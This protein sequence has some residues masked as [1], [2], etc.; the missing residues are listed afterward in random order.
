MYHRG[1]VLL[2]LKKEYI[3]GGGGQPKAG[4]LETWWLGKKNKREAGSSP[5][6]EK[7]F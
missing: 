6:Q 2:F 5:A 3:W 1:Q 7:W 4:A